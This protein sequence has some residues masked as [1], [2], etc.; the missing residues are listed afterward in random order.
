[1]K[2][3]GRGCGRGEHILPVGYMYVSVM[4]GKVG[5]VKFKVKVYG[6][7]GSHV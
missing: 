7:V 3:V 4:V 6:I 2:S 1:M 5:M